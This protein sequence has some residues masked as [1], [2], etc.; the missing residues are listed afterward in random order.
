MLLCQVPPPGLEP[1]PSRLEGE[2]PI[3]W[4]KATLRSLARPLEMRKAPTKR[5]L[6][7]LLRVCRGTRG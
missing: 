3:R 5:G 2:R 7:Y 6:W 4:T 1:G